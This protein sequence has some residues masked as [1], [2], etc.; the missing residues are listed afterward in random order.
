MSGPRDPGASATPYREAAPH[1]PTSVVRYSVGGP[2]AIAFSVGVVVAIPFICGWV[3]VTRWHNTE[4]GTGKG[5]A[6]LGAIAVSLLIPLVAVVAHLAHRVQVEV[7]HGAGTLV[8]RTMRWPLRPR[9]RTF[10]LARVTDAV[11]EPNDDGGAYMVFLVIEGASAVP[12]VEGAW[13]AGKERHERT[14]G[15]IRGLLRTRAALG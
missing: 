11:V 6:T 3:L 5:F 14:A 9:V 4:I 15:V 2:V 1:A 7:D 12:L 10:P 13:G 8:L